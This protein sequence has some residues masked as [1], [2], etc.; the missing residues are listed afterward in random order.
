MNFWVNALENGSTFAEVLEG[1]LVSEEFFALA[2]GSTEM[3]PIL[4]ASDF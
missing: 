1:F 2:A 4:S 3:A